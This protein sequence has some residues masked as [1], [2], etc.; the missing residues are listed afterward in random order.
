M[1]DVRVENGY[2][3]YR[4]QPY[5]CGCEYILIPSGV[6]EKGSAL[7]KAVKIWDEIPHMYKTTWI[8]IEAATA[9]IGYKWHSNGKSRFDKNYQ[10][11]LVKTA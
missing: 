6:D 5:P 3:I 1:H 4:D 9:P 7:F 8:P 10:T 11:I 2:V